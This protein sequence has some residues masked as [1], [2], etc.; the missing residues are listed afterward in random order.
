MKKSG[1]IILMAV[2]LGLVT[3][4][5]GF[6]AD[7][8]APDMGQAPAALDRAQGPAAPDRAQDPKDILQPDSIQLTGTVLSDN[9]FVDENGENYQLLESDTSDDLMAHV[10]QKIKVTATVM[11]SKDGQKNISISSYKLLDSQGQEPK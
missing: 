8:A 5:L 7:S 10:G 9:T 6:A 11:E 4:G 3:C 2:V 1:L